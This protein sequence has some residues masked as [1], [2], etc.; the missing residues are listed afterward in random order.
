MPYP[1]LYPP[2]QTRSS[3]P[4]TDLVGIIH[5]VRRRW[6]YK[7][8]LRGAVGVLGLGVLTLVL[9]A[10]GLEAWRFSPGSI[11]TFRVLIG[12]AA[13]ALLGWFIVRPLMRKATDEQVAMYL[14][15]HEPSLQAEIISAIEASRLAGSGESPHSAAL[16]GRLVQEAVEKCQA[17][18]SGR[19]VERVPLRRYA[20]SSA[21]IVLAAAALFMSGPMYLRHALTALFNVSRPVEAAA[22][23]R[24]EVT[25]GNA[26]VPKGVDQTIS[27]KLEGFDADQASL[28]VRKSPE[29]PFE[30]VPLVRSESADSPNQ[31]DG[32]LFDLTGNLD[33]FVEAAGV[34]SPTFSLK[35]VDL[36]Y[37]DKLE[38]EY[39]FPAYTGL[40]PR[41]VEDGGDIAVL[42]GTEVRVR[43]VPTMT[44]PGGQVLLHGKDGAPLTRGEDGSLTT[45]F[46]ADRDGFYRVEL[47]AP[48][49]E[50][51]SASPQYT[52]DVLSDQ[53]PS[54]SIAK[55]GRDTS[56][57]PIEEVFV[58]ARAEDDFGVRDLE[59]VYSVNGGA[60]KTVRLFDG[61]KR[62]P[63]VTAGHTFYLEELNLEPGDFVSYY[64]RAADNDAVQG[65]KKTSSDM[66]FLQIRPL[67]KEFRR[68]ESQGGGV[69]AGAAISRSATCRSSSVRSSRQPSTSIATGRRCLR[70]KLRESSTVI[71]LS[72]SRLREQVEGLLT[73]LN[74]RLV[75]QDP[76]FK[77]VADLLPLAVAEM[78]N[79]EA[80][81]QKAD[82]QGAL[83]P[84]QKA[85]Q[86]LQRA[87]EEYEVQV[88]M[89][90]GGGGGGGG[91]SQMAEDLADLFE[92]E[93]D[94]MSN[95]Y[96][97]A[98]RAQQQQ[99]DQ[100][101]DE[102]MEK[103]KE[104][105]RRQE[106]EAERQRRRAMAGQQQSGGGGQ[107]QRELAEQVEEAARRLEQ[108]SRE[109]N[110]PD[111]M[112]TARQLREAADQMRQAAS[113]GQT[114]SA[115]ASNALQRLQEA[116]RRLQQSQAGR[117]DRDLKDV[118]RQADEIAREQKSIADEVA[119]LDQQGVN[120]QERVQQL[121]ERK[122]QLEGRVSEL[123]KELD[124]S[125][126]D[127]ARSERETA[128]KLGEAA[129]S[130][131]DNRV[132][133][134]IRYSRSMIRAGV[135]AGDAA[136]FEGEIGSNIAEMQKK[137]GEAAAAMGKANNDPANG[138]L[139]K[140]QELTRGLE[141]LEERMR[142]RAGRDAGQRPG[143]QNQQGQQ[144]QQ[145]Q[146]GQ[147]GHRVS[148]ASRVSRVSKAN[149]VSKVSKV[150]KA[151]R[152]R[153]SAGPTG[154]ARAGGRSRRQE[155]RRSHDGWPWGRGQHFR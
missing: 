79:A 115:Q 124:R 60:E 13:L 144:G 27:A 37:V 49:G 130:L 98:Q 137:I 155:R 62:L 143:Q 25:P 93:L 5:L 18:E 36:P 34:K 8:L 68:A 154:S 117:A 113:E 7:L 69:A 50:R 35:V 41:K 21:L 55:P 94:K 127:M 83:E 4:P 61:K 153:R 129:G 2:L 134:K 30:R 84:E 76:A 51:V 85:L 24:I 63:E 58:E 77:K 74:S 131:R 28:M 111:L 26:T 72:Q 89:Q 99:A 32:M 136:R 106:Q 123:E 97:T 121:S 20:V 75:E 132:R 109:E 148:R 146:Q 103:L 96:Q 95:Q 40:E 139:E 15:E 116:Q 23:Y 102:L 142:E 81:L 33:Y 104:L 11:I 126:G 29:S 39:H 125:A 38:L 70:D 141:S 112:N 14:E 65:A 149:R 10:W 9:S 53:P 52:I 43:I 150:S 128:R 59:L 17:I 71:A 64:A 152:V 101:L 46:V 78:K 48:T 22:P 105:A 140:A 122:D 3:A 42:T 86:F 1:P 44:S 54:V 45:K 12:V 90:R 135:Q 120:R 57:S 92:L 110:R 88:A 114:A 19:N 91:N 80:R 66:Y 87:E 6:R 151:N 100:K 138:A 31:Y 147:Q 107:S 108:L 47:D 133:D 118:Q 82:P 119:G 73:R 67:R 56:A 145:N 16:V